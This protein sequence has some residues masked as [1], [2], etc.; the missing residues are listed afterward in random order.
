M[1]KSIL[2]EVATFNAEKFNDAQL[3]KTIEEYA[4][5]V[6]KFQ[7]DNQELSHDTLSN[8]KLVATNIVEET[9]NSNNL[10]DAKISQLE[11]SSAVF[12]E[13]IIN[14]FSINYKNTGVM[15]KDYGRRNIRTNE[16][17][18]QM[19]LYKLEDFEGPIMTPID[20][21][22][23]ELFD[24]YNDIIN[25]DDIN[26]TW[27]W[28]HERSLYY[29][30]HKLLTLDNGSASITIGD[31]QYK[32]TNFPGDVNIVDDL[33]TTGVM[34]IVSPLSS[35]DSITVNGNIIS[36]DGYLNVNSGM[37]TTNGDIEILGTGDI[38]TASGNISATG[39]ITTGGDISTSGGGVSASSGY[40][41]ETGGLIAGEGSFETGSGNFIS[42]DGYVSVTQGFT[43]T[44]GNIQTGG[45][46]D[47][48]TEYGNFTS[49]EG[50]LILTDGSFDVGNNGAVG[51]NL[52]V[53][54]KTITEYLDVNDMARFYGISNFYDMVTLESTLYVKGN[55]SQSTSASSQLN[56]LN[57][58][59]TFGMN[60]DLT[61]DNLTA[62][63][64]K[65]TCQTLQVNST[66]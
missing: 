35:M 58:T 34:T 19:F 36:T 25:N 52:T 2:Q 30:N 44:N 49:P 63:A 23:S 16:R 9:S 12:E 22:V 10:I 50:D 47:I 51:N 28:I 1:S 8:Y 3:R 40:T 31:I 42:E 7:R 46:G 48:I 33:A 43:S 66:S 18:D 61:A 56:N 45:S 24:H 32:T 62:T 38:K 20:G 65:V 60:G 26:R 55:I 57:V 54:A 27:I 4:S 41:T 14:E 59:G 13:F 17:I 39:T 11:I 21:T 64:G 29:Q 6:D 5:K 37:S 53:A 15:R